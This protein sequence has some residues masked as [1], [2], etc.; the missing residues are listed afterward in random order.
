MCGRLTQSMTWAQ[1][2]RL[3]NLPHDARPLNLQAR[4]NA[5]PTQD[6][7][8]CRLDL[9]GEREVV[10]MRWGLIP[11]WAKDMKMG[12]RLI[13]ARAETVHTKPSFRSAFLR[14]RCTVPVDGWFE[15]RQE[16]HGK[17]PYFLA[18]LNAQPLSFAGLWERWTRADESIE[19]L[20]IIT[21]GASAALA[22]VHH[23]QPAIVGPDQLEAWLDPAS[24]AERLFEIVRTACEGPFEVRKISALVNSVR[25]DT[26]DILTPAEAVERR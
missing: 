6:L 19:S 9:A 17:Q 25:N 12:A 22:A 14:R 7:A 26:P 16:P 24:P 20:T 11:S 5:A 13:N 2:H 21:T 1:I 15:W 10:T 8:A 18:A 3:Y 23:R 4:Y